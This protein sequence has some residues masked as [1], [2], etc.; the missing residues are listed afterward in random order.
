MSK[1]S[2]KIYLFTLLALLIAGFALSAGCTGNS[3]ADKT[4]AATATPTAEE[5]TA[6]TPEET[7]VKT[8]EAT[9]VS[10]EEKATISGTGDVNASVEFKGGVH[11]LTFTQ[12]KPLKSEIAIQTEKD[13]IGL[14]SLFNESVAEKS[15]KDGRYYWT[16]AFMLEENAVADVEVYTESE[17][18]LDFSFP[19]MI[20]GIVPQTFTGVGNKATPFFQINEGEYKF[21]IK[22]DN[23]QLVEVHLMDY[24]GNPVLADNAEMPLAYHEGSYDDVVTVKITE[25]NNYLI[26]V[27]CDGEWTVSVEEA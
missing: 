5:T 14:T 24:Y 4:P 7:A 1:I 16:Q 22:A 25:D 11:L 9:P 27:V 20:N 10:G 18:T 21:S 12:D 17:W 19:Q 6:A 26:N 3:G 8:P 23:S 2:S 13:Y 15:M